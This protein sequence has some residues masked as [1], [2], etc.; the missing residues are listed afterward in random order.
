MVKKNKIRFIIVMIFTSK[1]LNYY[2]SDKHNVPCLK[3]LPITTFFHKRRRAMIRR[4]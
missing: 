1:L 3:K 4:F 2:K